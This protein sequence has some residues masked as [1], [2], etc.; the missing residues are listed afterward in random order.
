MNL[1][2]PLNIRNTFWKKHLCW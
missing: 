1:Q 2:D